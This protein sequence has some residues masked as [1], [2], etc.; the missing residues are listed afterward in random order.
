VIFKHRQQAA[1]Y[2][3]ART[4]QGMQQLRLFG[5]RLAETRLHAPRLEI[6]TVGNR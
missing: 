3:Q 6:F 2:R 4:V 1:A 5:I